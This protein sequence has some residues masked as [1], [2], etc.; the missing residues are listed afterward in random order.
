MSTINKLDKFALKK[1]AKDAGKTIAK[2]IPIK[3]K[4]DE[5]ST[6]ATPVKKLN[7]KKYYWSL[8]GTRYLV[9]KKPKVKRLKL[10]VWNIGG[11]HSLFYALAYSV[12]HARKVL[13]KDISIKGNK[14]REEKLAEE[15]VE[16]KRPTSMLITF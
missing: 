9:S 10:Y 4:W 1:I 7:T 5:D 14:F 6:T 2:N 11:A 3:P 15:P 13:L 12:D 8:D 16:F